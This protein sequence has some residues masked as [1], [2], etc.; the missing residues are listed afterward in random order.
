MVLRPSFKH[1]L[2]WCTKDNLTNRSPRN[3]VSSITGIR[4]LS[5]KSFLSKWSSFLAHAYRL[6]S[7][8]YCWSLFSIWRR[9]EQMHLFIS[10]FSSKYKTGTVITFMFIQMVY[11][12]RIL[13]LLLQFFQNCCQ[14]PIADVYSGKA[15]ANAQWWSCRTICRK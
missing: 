11:L 13:W 10:T 5:R 2:E 7:A 9:I 1:N 6:L 4:R 14:L 3:V 12:I 8:A 15:A